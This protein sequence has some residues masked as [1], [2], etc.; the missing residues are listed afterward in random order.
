[1]RQSIRAAA[2][3][4]FLIVLM[5]GQVSADAPT[6][7]TGPPD[8]ARTYGSDHEAYSGS[9]DAT[10]TIERDGNLYTVMI[11]NALDAA[12]FGV[13]LFSNVEVQCWT[14]KHKYTAPY[15]DVTLKAK[16]HWC[17]TVNAPIVLH[18][19]VT[20]GKDD[21]LGDYWERIS[22]SHSIRSGGHGHTYVDTKARGNWCYDHL[23]QGCS[24]KLWIDMDT[25]Q[26][27]DGIARAQA[28]WRGESQ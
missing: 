26:Y 25:Q 21:S 23:D 4:V 17:A 7:G 28:T 2:V 1:M 27:A 6:P 14:A 8:T 13:A 9:G 5:V 15:D 3:A 19:K 24:Y 12:T 16:V 11:S 18:G 22:L 10:T 20:L